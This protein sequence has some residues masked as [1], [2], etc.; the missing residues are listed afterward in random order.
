MKNYSYL[1]THA[2]KMIIKKVKFWKKMM[3]R[4]NR[5]K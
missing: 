4:Q 2:E 3:I 1:I 5:F